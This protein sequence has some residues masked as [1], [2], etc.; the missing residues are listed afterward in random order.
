[1]RKSTLNNY[2]NTLSYHY[3][4]DRRSSEVK[5]LIKSRDNLQKQ[6]KAKLGDK[7]KQQLIFGS[8]SRDTILPRDYDEKSD[9]DLLIVFKHSKFERT[10]NTYRNWLYDFADRNY[11][12]R[13][14]TTILR[15][16]PTVAIRLRKI[17]FDLVP[18][19]YEEEWW[20]SGRYMIPDKNGGWMQTNPNDVKTNLTAA[21]KRHNNLVKKVIR[22]LKAWN[23]KS[24]YPFDSY[25]LENHLAQQYYIGTSLQD[26]FFQA[27]RS[28]NFGYY[29]SLKKQAKVKSLKKNIS[30]VEQAL[31]EGNIDR[32][33][34]W[35]HK[36]LPVPKKRK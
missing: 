9:I 25:L 1:M 21:N 3:Y 36:I 16:H 30:T 28:L 18:A 23:A 11:R 13:Y 2:L 22:L 35:L 33:K 6:L 27:A 20:G 7:I 17:H 15:S 19:K 29:D 5:Q 4:I 34:H 31:Y 24:K 32:A 8:Y 10:P 14:G 26:V 12:K